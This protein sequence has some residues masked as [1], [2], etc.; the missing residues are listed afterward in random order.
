MKSNF[1][2]II[3]VFV[4]FLFAFFLIAYFGNKPVEPVDNG[5]VNNN[6]NQTNNGQNI[7]GNADI[8]NPNWQNNTSTTSAPDK[9]GFRTHKS[10]PYGFSFRYPSDWKLVDGNPIMLYDPIALAQTIDTELMQGMKI[11]IY[12]GIIGPDSNFNGYIKNQYEDPYQIVEDKKINDLKIIKVE[13]TG[14]YAGLTTYI[15]DGDTV[16]MIPLHLGNKNDRS[17]YLPEYDRIL[18]DAVNSLK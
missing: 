11:E 3:I 13:S 17:K 6:T 12:R 9:D 15:K 1:K 14:I 2:K 5:Q 18:D 8:D 4:V 10:G 16:F 7:N